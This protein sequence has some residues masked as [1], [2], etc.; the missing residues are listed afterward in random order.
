MGYVTSDQEGGAGKGQ[1]EEEEEE[2]GALVGGKFS[3]H[4]L[5]VTR[6]QH[7]SQP[8]DMRRK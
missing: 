5:R 1:E 6:L 4:T 2:E 8:L 7:F 3:L